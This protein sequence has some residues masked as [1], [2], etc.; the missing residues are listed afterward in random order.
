MGQ[1]NN[2]GR[3]GAITVHGNPESFNKL[4][5]SHGELCKVK[6]ALVCPFC[7]G[8]NHGSP[9]YNCEICGGDGYI[10]TYQRRFLV[11]DENSHTAGKIMSPYWTPILGIDKIENVTS[12][13]QGGI[14]QLEFNHFTETQIILKEP[15]I[16]YE[17]KRVSYYFDGWTYVAREKLRVDAVNKIMY[18]DGTAYLSTYTSSN[19]YRAYADIAKVA[20]IWNDITGK[21]I[22][23]YTVYG[24]SI[25]TTQSVDAD[26]MYI[27]YYYSDLTEAVSSDLKNKL[28]NEKW[29][30]DIESGECQMAFYPFIELSRGDLLV[31]PATVLYKNET[32]IHQKDLD[33]L[34]EVEIFV[35]N[36]R[37]LDQDGAVYHLDTDYILQGRHIKWIGDKPAVGKAISLRYGYKPAYIVFEDNAEPNNRE[38]RAYP[39]LVMAKSWSKTKAEDVAKLLVS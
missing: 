31:F 36:D 9:D 12:E 21:E 29:T 35:L 7:A 24:N 8:V 4:I 33:R 1:N 37:I 14:T 20:K 6:Q 17:R 26:N 27:E 39:T 2:P 25:A 13:I 5:R 22:T 32:L 30:H 16:I 19:P 11:V 28:I 15:A 10:Y 23:K 3:E 18:A 34:H 38:N